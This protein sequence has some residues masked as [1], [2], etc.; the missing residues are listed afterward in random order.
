MSSIQ[1]Y[2]ISVAQSKVDTLQKKLALTTLPDELDNSGW[3]YGAPLAD[4]KRLVAH[5]QNDYDWRAHERQ[6]NASLPQY[7]ISIDVDDFGPLT[8]HFVHQESAITGA[9]PLLFCHGWPGHFL[10]VSKI[11][12]RLVQGGGD[13]QQP[14][15]HV[16]APSLINYGFSD[17]V[18]QR[19]FTMSKHA[20]VCHKLMRA[21]GYAEYVTQGGDWGYVVTR[22]MGHYYPTSCRASHLN[23][24]PVVP[25]YKNPLLAVE[26][27][28]KYLVLGM[29]EALKR[30]MARAQHFGKEGMGYYK[31]Q[32]TKPQTIGYSQA[33]SPVG[34]LAWIYE[35]LHDW[36]DAYPWTDD[37]IL[38]WVSIYAF[39]NAGPA[40]PSRT[41]YGECHSLSPARTGFEVLNVLMKGGGARRMHARERQTAFKG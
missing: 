14:A 1:R 36:T 19:G 34:L 41:Y 6:I 21:L 25:S 31:E 8:V 30:G 16:V 32:S 39:S 23:M 7:T 9:I 28:S 29:D 3:D 27:Y 15:F 22:L 33:D 18:K 10:E 38:T 2:Q 24:Y 35:K 37:E 4:I 11:L 13:Q 26:F 20:E 40:A 12:P 17:G 5:W